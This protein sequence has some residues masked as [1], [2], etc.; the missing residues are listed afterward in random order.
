MLLFRKMTKIK[1]SKRDKTPPR[2]EK[3]VNRL[4]ITLGH[5][6][7]SFCFM[8]MA[9]IEINIR[10]QKGVEGVSGDPYSKNTLKH[11]KKTFFRRGVAKP[12]G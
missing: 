10:L 6:R 2:T 4:K 11:P 8:S 9:S 3:G 1:G 5:K 7:I 12:G